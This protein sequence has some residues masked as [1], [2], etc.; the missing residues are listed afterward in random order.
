MRLRR[1][2]ACVPNRGD[3]IENSDNE[4][5]CV[6]E[7]AGDDALSNVTAAQQARLG[8]PVIECQ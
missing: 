2:V 3:E 8:R 4:D 6:F 5:C 7:I 1:K